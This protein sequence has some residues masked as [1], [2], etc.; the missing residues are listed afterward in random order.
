MFQERFIVISCSLSPR[1]EKHTTLI[2]KSLHSL[3][4]PAHIKNQPNFI[5][6]KNSI[7]KHFMDSYKELDLFIM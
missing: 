7:F 6:F 3:Y 1:D 4:V 2:E 5:R